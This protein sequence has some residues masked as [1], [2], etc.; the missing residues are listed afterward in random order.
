L[1]CLLEPSDFMGKNFEFYPLGKG[2]NTFYFM[3]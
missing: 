3:S 2:T 1:A